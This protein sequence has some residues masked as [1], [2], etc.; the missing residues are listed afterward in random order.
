MLCITILIA[1]GTNSCSSC[2]SICNDYRLAGGSN[3]FSGVEIT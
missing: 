2:T 3:V 1:K